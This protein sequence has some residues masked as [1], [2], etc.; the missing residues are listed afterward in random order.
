MAKKIVTSLGETPLST[1]KVAKMPKMASTIDPTK[2]DQN[3]FSQIQRMESGD[4]SIKIILFAISI[5]VVGVLLVL[6]IKNASTGN[7][8]TTTSAPESNPVVSN[9]NNYYVISTT[10]KADATAVKATE[11]DQYTDSATLSGGDSTLELSNISLSKIIYTSYTSFDRIV[12]DLTSISGKLPKFMVEYDS[13]KNMLIVSLP[14]LTNI[15]S[16]LK[17]DVTIGGLVKE[18]R[19]DSVNSRH[20]IYLSEN[21]KYNVFIDGTDLIIDVKANSTEVTPTPEVTATPVVTPTPSPVATDTNKPEAPFYDNEFSQNTQYISSNVTGNTI[22]TSTFTIEDTGTYFEIALLA[23][24]FTGEQYNPNVKAY[25]TTKS[26]V[27][28]LVI[29]V[30]NIQTTFMNNAGSPYYQN[31]SA[32]KIQENIGV[33]MSAANFV[34]MAFVSL[35]NGKAKYEIE[36]KKKADYKIKVD[37]IDVLGQNSQGLIIQI[38]D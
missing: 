22:N 19:F 37:S 18:I 9:T 12:F 20:L 6:F 34:N 29:E 4:S 16:E 36:L 7:Q 21:F 23:K 26:S 13:L 27:N 32:T 5:I 2:L 38:K 10:K 33:N 35:S 17:K 15:E 30:E 11:D 8:V 14:N 3:R 28:Y 31:I 24:G 1:K 25:L